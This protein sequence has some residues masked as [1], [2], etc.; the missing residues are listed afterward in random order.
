MGL[1]EQGTVTIIVKG[2]DATSGAFKSALGN[3]QKLG[4]TL[5]IGIGAG[6][7]AAGAAVAGFAAKGVSE[8]VKFEDAM[9]EVFTLLPGISEQAM[10]EMEANVLSAAKEMGRLPDEV[11]PALYQSLSAGVPADNV[12]SYL[13]QAHKTALAGVTDLD[14]AVDALSSIMNAYGSDVISAEKASDLLFTAVKGGKTTMGEL[15]SS[16]SRITPTTAALGVEFADVTAALATITS[17]GVKTKIASTQLAALFSELS[18]EG[19]KVDEVFREVAGKGFGDFIKAG[20][21]TQGALGLLKDYADDAGLSMKDLF[22]NVTAG[23]AALILAGSGAEKFAQEL[24]NMASSAG[25]TDE[26][27]EIMNQGIARTIEQLQAGFVATLIQVGDA[28]APLV[29]MLGEGLLAAFEALTP[30]IEQFVG[31]FASLGGALQG[32]VE[33]LQ[34][35]MPFLEAL[36]NLLS[37]IFINIFGLSIQQA[38]AFQAT[39]DAVVLKIQEFIAQL[40]LVA[41]PIIA[42]VEENV[43]LQDVLVAL[44]LILASVILPALASLIAGFIAVA[45]PVVALI[46]VVALLRKAW[47]TDFGGMRTN[48]T[49][50]WEGTVRPA[51]ENL[52]VWL[53]ENIPVALQTLSDFWSNVLLPAI[54][55]VVSFITGTLFP[56]LAELV[57]TALE[58]VRQMTEDLSTVWNEVLLPAITAVQGFI[59]DTLIPILVELVDNAMENVRQMTEDLS[60]LW[61]DTLKPALEAVSSFITGTLIPALSNLYNWIGE[62]IRGAIETTK[63]VIDG[64]KGAFDSIVGAI[65]GVI[66]KVKSL[67]SWLSQISVPDIVLPGSPT[68]FEIGLRGISDALQE[69]NMSRLPQFTNQLGR[70]RINDAYGGTFSPMSPMAETLGTG[71]GRQQVVNNEYNLF[72]TTSAGA[73][74]IINDFQFMEAGLL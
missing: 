8:F 49:A 2:K 56:T 6:A 46:A 16:I 7:V 3:V 32:F 50:F 44:G 54:E 15:G 9:N 33:N 23:D 59:A 11:I 53:A 67:I 26:A 72:L 58:N 19:T 10:G 29:K 73:D 65:Q 24:D 35:G 17:T 27:Y 51:L 5:A 42:W 69:L 48:L 20:G 52:R 41:A 62:K 21:D 4:K 22:G 61:K 13:E 18:K 43:K 30:Y 1:S 40:M 60:A 57:D 55:A 38:L 66:D 12:F 70:I 37:N 36:K 34:G 25:A 31:G 64:L 14:V 71:S 47:E 74:S 68:P 63:G 39:F 28:L 45:A